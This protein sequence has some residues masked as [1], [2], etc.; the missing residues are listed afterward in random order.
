MALFAGAGGCY[1]GRYTFV[2]VRCL[3]LFPIYFLYFVLAIEVVCYFLVVV[4][5][6]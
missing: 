3:A 6:F 5:N 4:F 2:K 1:V